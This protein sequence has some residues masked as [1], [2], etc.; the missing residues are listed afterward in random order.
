M[1]QTTY[2]L[3]EDTSFASRQKLASLDSLLS[4]PWPRRER[5]PSGRNQRFR[6]FPDLL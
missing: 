2:G 5:L 6:Q 3:G 1:T 4:K